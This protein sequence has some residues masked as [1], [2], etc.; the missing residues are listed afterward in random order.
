MNKRTKKALALAAAVTSLGASLGVA[1]SAEK[2]AR[3]EIKGDNSGV[4]G[5]SESNH[6][7]WAESREN[8]SQIKESNSIKMEKKVNNIKGADS[9]SATGTN[10]R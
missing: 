6:I 4:I 5:S 7:K 9:T 3:N 8:S 2:W 10:P 1:Q